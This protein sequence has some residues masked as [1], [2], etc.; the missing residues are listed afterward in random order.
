LE[1]DEEWLNGSHTKID[2]GSSDEE[3]S[4]DAE[5]QDD[6]KALHE[7]ADDKSAMWAGD[8]DVK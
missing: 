1:S 2:D 6:I 7:D 8:E 4:D 3:S 5:D